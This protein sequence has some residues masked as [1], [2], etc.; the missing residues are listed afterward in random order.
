VTILLGPGGFQPHPPRTGEGLIE[1][2][3]WYLGLDEAERMLV[4]APRARNAPAAK[5]LSPERTD[6]FRINFEVFFPPAHSPFFAFLH[7]PPPAR[8]K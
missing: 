4:P 6:T 2:Y 8:C 5:A 3:P 7:P 1:S